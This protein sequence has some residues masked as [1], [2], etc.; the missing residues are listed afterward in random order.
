MHDH[1]D[2]TQILKRGAFVICL[3]AL[4]FFAGCGTDFGDTNVV[5]GSGHV[6]T[7]NRSVTNFHAIDLTGSG[8]LLIRQ[9]DSDSLSIEAEDNL[10]PLIESTVSHGELRLSL[11]PNTN[12]SA[13]RPVIYHVTV[14]S[15]SGLRLSGSGGAKVSDLHG[16]SL[17]VSITGSGS[18]D[19]AGQVDRQKVHIAG[20]G[21]YHATAL[22]SKDIEIDI[23]GSGSASLNASDDLDARI[24]G[25]GSIEYKGRPA[26]SSHISGSGRV[27]PMDGR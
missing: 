23:S 11:K 9:S 12:I 15:L 7:E 24:S 22:A 2:I 10:L 19:V 4:P 5:H 27:R 17:D 6:S 8:R 14:K 20:S 26:V 1:Q 21:S 16:D 13:S 18:I 3:L 25:S